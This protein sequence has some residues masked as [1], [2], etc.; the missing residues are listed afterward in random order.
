MP[1]PVPKFELQC[2]DAAGHTVAYVTE[3]NGHLIVHGSMQAWRETAAA[4]LPIIREAAAQCPRE[5]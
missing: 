1:P 5:P 4:L 3:S 2:H